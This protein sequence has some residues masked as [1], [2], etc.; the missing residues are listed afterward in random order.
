MAQRKRHAREFKICPAQDLG[1]WAMAGHGLVEI[2][3]DLSS[4]ELYC[5]N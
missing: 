1:G 5:P 3:I 2:Y 4:H